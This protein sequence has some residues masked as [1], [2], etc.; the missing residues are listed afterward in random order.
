MLVMVAV[1]VF[2][3]FLNKYLVSIWYYTEI[4]GNMSSFNEILLGLLLRRCIRT[5]NDDH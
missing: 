1:A 2:E 5:V 3:I 4:I